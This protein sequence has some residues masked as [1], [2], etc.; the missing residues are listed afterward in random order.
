M[1]NKL[2]AFLSLIHVVSGGTV[3]QFCVIL[4]DKLLGHVFIRCKLGR[5]GTKT[6][7]LRII[8]DN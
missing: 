2:N 6:M 5:H 3:E 7:Q 1:A 4:Y 8:F